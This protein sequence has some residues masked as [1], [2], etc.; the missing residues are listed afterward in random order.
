MMT[1]SVTW[2]FAGYYFK[3]LDQA[4]FL[5]VVAHRIFWSFVLFFLIL[6]YRRKARNLIF[7]IASDRKTSLITLLGCSTITVNWLLFIYAVQNEMATQASLGYFIFPLVA[8]FVSFVFLDE[9][10]T[11]LQWGS[12][13][14]ASI[15]VGILTIDTGSLPWVPL[16]LAIS[17]CV[18]GLVKRNLKA[19]PIVSVTADMMLV[20]PFA[21]GFLC[22]LHVV[23]PSVST[24]GP[25]GFFGRDAGYT[26][27]FVLSGLLTA[28]PLIL[29]SYA[30]SRIPYTEVGLIS[31]LTPSIQF[32]FATLVMKEAVSTPAI[33]TFVLIWIALILYSVEQFRLEKSARS[34]SITPST[35]LS[36]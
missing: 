32:L 11:K 10:F 20:M 24:T 14:M 28:G 27:M 3:L 9:R 33:M 8:A 19:D 16:S 17:F 15:G 5:E 30:T 36:E 29:M 23:E 12:I 18:Y 1:A 25:A 4:R 2:G 26:V 34:R 6:L 13:V 35:E 7:L 22:Y 21:L 31:Y